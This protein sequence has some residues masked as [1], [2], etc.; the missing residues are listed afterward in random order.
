MVTSS[1]PQSALTDSSVSSET[2]DSLFLHLSVRA[3]AFSFSALETSEAVM[4]EQVAIVMTLQL[5]MLQAQIYAIGKI[6]VRNNLCTLEG[7]ES[8]IHE[9][10]TQNG[11]DVASM[12]RRDLDTQASGIGI[13]GQSFEELLQRM[14]DNQAL[15]KPIQGDNLPPDETA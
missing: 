11:A 8:E 10:W 9:Y 15:W 4:D 2:P 13:T 7:F 5:T 3:Q 12:I 6:L 14:R 1:C